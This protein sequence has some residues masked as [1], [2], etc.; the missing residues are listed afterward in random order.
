MK[1]H[2]NLVSAAMDFEMGDPFDGGSLSPMQQPDTYDD[3]LGAQVPIEDI[4]LSMPDFE[5]EYTQSCHTP[6][7]ANIVETTAT[8]QHE[9]M[10]AIMNHVAQSHNQD[11][12]EAQA[13]PHKETKTM[14]KQ[15]PLDDPFTWEVAMNNID[16]PIEISDTEDPNPIYKRCADTSN[17]TIAIPESDI[18]DDV[19]VLNPDGSSVPIKKE[20]DEVKFLWEKIGNRVIELDADDEPSVASSVNLGKS[21]LRR[22]DF[23]GKRPPRDR[24]GM[25]RAQ[26]AFIRAHQRNNGI[27]EPSTTQKG[28]I[29]LGIQGP[30]RSDLSVDDIEFPRMKADH[31][32]D[33]DNGSAFRTLKKSYKAKVKA[34]SNT[35][36]DDIEFRKAEKVERLRLARLQAEYE[37][38]R[39]YSD[40]DNSDDGLFVSPS[41]TDSRPKRCALDDSDSGDDST[42]ARSAKQ[43]KPNSKGKRSKQGTDLE[44][45]TNMM[46]GI[47]EFLRKTYGEEGDKSGKKSNG[48]KK[49]ESKRKRRPKK[50]GYLNGSNTLLTSNVYEDADSNLNREALPV[51]GHTHKQKALAALVASVP[52]GTP[53]KDAISEKNRIL[54][55]T[56][57]LGRNIKGSCKADGEN[58]WKLT[59]MKSSLR[60]HQ[61][62]G[63]SFMKDRETGGE[64][65]L[66]GILV[67]LCPRRIARRLLI[68]NI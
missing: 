64:E 57:N 45:E 48:G 22:L 67:S 17:N 31:I 26:E 55:A 42:M 25:M 60:H 21:F 24:S 10:S 29:G 66:G 39:G 58:N 12:A 1:I 27:S 33:E 18:D 49:D 35:I 14:I 9:C 6:P 19:L 2:I 68:F 43:R 38:A 41:V 44:Q 5:S 8:V 3:L 61:V 50:T 51:S 4:D 20:D 36:T 46:A 59:G 56:V 62:L 63:A 34:D 40:D 54:K 52:L 23:K 47:E 28:L 37:D 13:S 15:E 7:I 16:D 30:K 11:P 32:S 65:P 53:Q